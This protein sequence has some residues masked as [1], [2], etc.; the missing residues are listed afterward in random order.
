M[1]PFKHTS[2]KWAVQYPAK[3]G[4]DGKREMRYYKTRDDALE[5]I[6]D[7]TN[8]HHEHGK[9][10]V[11]AKQR[12]WI[13]FAEKQLGDLSLLPEVI[14]HWK[15]TGERLNQIGT[16]KAVAEFLESAERD[17]ENR[18]TL[19]DI[20]ERLDKFKKAFSSCSLH[21]ITPTD[22]EKW[23]EGYSK[24]WDRWSYHKRLGPFFKLAKRR[25]WVSQNPME[26]V[27]KPETP[28]PERKI[29]NVE[30]FEKLLHNS[31]YPSKYEAIFPYVILCGFCFLRTAELVKMYASEKVL[32]WEHVLMDKG[33]I[34]V[35]KGVAKSTRRESGDERYIPLSDAAK[36][37]LSQVRPVMKTGDCIPHSAKKFGEPWRSLIKIAGVP[38]IDNGLRHSAI[39]YSLAANPQHGVALTAQWAGNSEKT[40]RKHYRRL[41]EPEQG[42]AWF[43]LEP[44]LGWNREPEPA[45]EA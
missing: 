23:L 26:E 24:G 21:E 8:E 15:R 16:P 19:N 2:G 17:Y 25:R 39:S 43:N 37:W 6:K 28:T 42:K 40:I 45:L 30:Q 14:R 29:Y 9:S 41:I 20:K 33:L 4:K 12:E 35:P 10:G 11:T 44:P 1:K 27:P 22:I 31:E 32:T 38:S 5:G 18:R 7:V 13:N 3:Y 36:H 34:Y